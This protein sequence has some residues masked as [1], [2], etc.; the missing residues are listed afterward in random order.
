[1][2]EEYTEEQKAAIAAAE[3]LLGLG[4]DDDEEE[5]EA[6][7]T[8]APMPGTSLTY[9]RKVGEPLQVGRVSGPEVTSSRSGYDE[10]DMSDR[11]KAFL[12]MKKPAAPTLAQ[13]LAGGVTGKRDINQSVTSQLDATKMSVEMW[14]GNAKGNLDYITDMARYIV[15]Y[16]DMH[17]CANCGHVQS[18]FGFSKKQIVEMLN[19][20]VAI[21]DVVDMSGNLINPNSPTD[22]H[23]LAKVRLGLTPTAVELIRHAMKHGTVKRV[24]RGPIPM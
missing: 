19:Q 21:F 8:V 20:N 6:A 2:A 16:A 4:D 3:A 18:A 11:Q 24:R 13:A 14:A 15:R 22:M 9:E 7:P 1:M 5:E 10:S 17:G 23:L 12:D